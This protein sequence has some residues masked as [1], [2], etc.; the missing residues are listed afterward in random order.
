MDKSATVFSLSTMW[1]NSSTTENSIVETRQCFCGSRVSRALNNVCAVKGESFLCWLEVRPRDQRSPQLCSSEP[2]SQWAG[3][4]ITHAGAIAA[5]ELQLFVAGA[6][7]LTWST[8]KHKDHAQNVDRFNAPGWEN[9]E[10][11][12]ALDKCKI[13][14]PGDF[15]N[16]TFILFQPLNWRPVR[17]IQAP[18]L[19]C[20][21]HVFDQWQVN[22]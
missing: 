3:P 20:K 21:M 22:I 2:S 10:E 17:V 14:V 19:W 5:T 4:D 15:C 12:L 9:L 18:P 1:N 11:P 6:E 8:R 7:R 13:Q 16:L